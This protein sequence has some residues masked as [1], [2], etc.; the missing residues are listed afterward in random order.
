M[1]VSW[2]DPDEI[3]ALLAK[4][5]GPRKAPAQ[6]AW[7]IHTLPVQPLPTVSSQSI[8]GEPREP[9]MAA[10]PP[11]PP[12]KAKPEPVDFPLSDHRP[13]PDSGDI[14]NIR[15]QLRTLREKAEVSGIV[16][17]VAPVSSEAKPPEQE[18]TDANEPVALSPAARQAMETLLGPSGP[19]P[20]A[21]PRFD[22]QTLPPPMEPPGSLSAKAIEYAGPAPS[23]V[24]TVPLFAKAA[25]PSDEPAR[26]ITQEEALESAFELALQG[27]EPESLSEHAVP[28][29][30]AGES[31]FSVAP[32]DGHP[33]VHEEAAAETQ[34]PEAPESHVFT[35]PALGLSD[36]LN[37][38][39][40]WA[41]KR[42]GTEEVL[43]V[44]D[45]GDVLWGGQQHT[46]LVLAAMMAWHSSQ[47]ANAESAA[48][49]PV[50]IQKE[51]S[52]GRHLTVI[53]VRTRYG[54]VSLAAISGAKIPEAEIAATRTALL[55]AVEGA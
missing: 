3:Q 55:R 28:T 14:W 34:A 52:E 42:L 37:A 38:L 51:I 29:A 30:E 54:T 39:A 11:P 13:G 19:Q 9:E 26:A 1:Q 2:I 44:D 35:P 43:L 46:A 23:S 22:P 24:N 8:L 6:V 20:V 4:I 47:R 33:A 7:E 12:P 17:A 21:P 49:N 32:V 40:Q 50:C 45:F 16:P 27:A 31:P 5:E 41:S 53:P 15:E 36:R 48:N 25:A 10:P 18:P